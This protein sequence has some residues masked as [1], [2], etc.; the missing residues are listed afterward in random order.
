MSSSRSQ[1]I[2]GTLPVIAALLGNGFIAVLKFVGFFISGSGAMLSE[3]I[4]SFADTANQALLMVGI[5]RS[6]KKAT[7]EFS[8][9]Y[10]KERFLWAL[11]SACGIFFVGAGA[12]IYQGINALIRPQHADVTYIVFT[13]LAI[14]FVI[15]SGTLIVAYRELR[16]TGGKAKFKKILK[17]G[18]PA[19]IAVLYED[20]IAVL[21]VVV[22]FVSILLTELTGAYYWDAIGSIVIGLMLGVMAIILI[23]KNR[24]LLLGKAIPEEVKDRIIEILEED[25]AIESVTDFR[26]AIM[27]VGKYRIKCEVEFNGNALAKEMFARGALREEF[28]EVRNDYQ[29]FIKFCVDYIDRVPRLVG[30]HI[31]KIEKRIQEE[32]PEVV[33]IDIELN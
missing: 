13:I 30:N 1:S 14:S 11:I 24:A 2:Q 18:D 31:D 15:E 19:T 7:N 3:A 21:G 5:R 27:D 9:G 10:G 25:P 29:E 20:G 6:K 32:Y 28:E 16:K 8:Y 33:H 4:H 17:N 22:A 12:T 23:N 26:S